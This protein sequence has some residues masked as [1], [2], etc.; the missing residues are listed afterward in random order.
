[1]QLREAFKRG[2]ET[3]LAVLDEDLCKIEQWAKGREYRSVLYTERNTL[4]EEQCKA[5]LSEIAGMREL[6]RELRDDLG[7]EGR[8]RSA[9]SD[10]W[11]KCAILAVDLEELKGRYLS[12]YGTP[13]AELVEYLDPRVIRLI[14]SVNHI[15]RLVE[16]S[17]I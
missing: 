4:S 5:I 2:I 13:P 15:F 6:L 17:R 9:A 14:A 12:R 7:L 16:K 3:T 10:I 8:V 11:G 1:M